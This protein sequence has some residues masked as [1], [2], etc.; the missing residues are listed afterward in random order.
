LAEIKSALE[1]AL[2]KAEKYGRASREEMDLAQYRDQG[3]RLAVQY[4]KGEGDLEADLKSLPPSALAGA[5]QAIKEVL[6]RNLALPRENTEDPRLDRAME[7][8]MAAADKPKVMANLLVEFEQ[9]VQNFLQIR[10]NTLQ[11]LKNRFVA[12]VGQVQKALEAQYRQKVSLDVEK[13]PQFQEE[14]RRFHGQILDQF[15]PMLANLKEK[16]RQA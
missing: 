4:L 15:E 7:G 5:R 10:T 3:C 1:L 8:L 6:L 2:E 14:W 16:I 11:Q 12:G 9:L 13:L